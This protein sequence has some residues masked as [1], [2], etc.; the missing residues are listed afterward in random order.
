MTISSKNSACLSLVNVILFSAL[1][2]P[3][4]AKAEDPTPLRYGAGVTYQR[5]SNLF[6]LDGEATG[7]VQ[8]DNI[9]SGY[10]YLGF[11]TTLSR[12]RLYGNFNIGRAHFSRFSQLDYDKQ[13]IKTGWSGDFPGQIQTGLVWTRTSQ[14]AN[15]AD[16]NLPRRNVITR[17]A[18]R[19]DLDVPVIASWH[20]VAAGTVNQSRNS[21]TLDRGNDL[22]GHSAEGGVRYVTNYGNRLDLVLQQTNVD[23]PNR[24]P[25]DY[26]DSAYH[27]RSAYLRALWSASGSSRLEGQFGYLQRRNEHYSNQDFSG[28]NFKLGWTWEPSG[29]TVVAVTAYRTMGAAG[30][31]EYEAAATKALRISPVWAI[32]GKLSLAGQ[33]EAGQRSYIGAVHDVSLVPE[34]EDNFQS[35]GVSLHYDLARWLGL[36]LGYRGERRDSNWPQRDYIDHTGTVTVQIG[37]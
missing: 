33:I 19:L 29:S 14:L 28:P 37:F 10:A 6:R 30:D 23:Y 9:T 22:D 18:V 31:N 34:R 26:G 21:N 36:D 1:A 13:D 8:S 3:Q 32:T 16:L 20:I 24:I 5:D 11:D 12:Q 7:E 27:E 15:F 17:D 2:V 35:L 4:C 25:Q